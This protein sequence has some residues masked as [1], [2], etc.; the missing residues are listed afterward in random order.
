MSCRQTKLTAVLKDALGG[1]CKTIMVANV[2]PEPEHLE[3]TVSTL[4]FAARVK[5]LLTDAVVNESADPTLLLKRAERQ[6]RELKQELTMR[7]MLRW[8]M[9][10]ALTVLLDKG[11]MCLW[12][13]R[14]APP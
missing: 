13:D 8:V 1:N 3:E 11:H 4:R 10:V 12:Q 14:L 2:W 6:I 7:D 5:T 9:G